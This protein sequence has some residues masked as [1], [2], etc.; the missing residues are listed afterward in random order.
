MTVH[1]TLENVTITVLPALDQ[2]KWIVLT[3]HTTH[4]GN[5]VLD[6]PVT[7]NGQAITARSTKAL[8][9]SNVK[10]DVMD[11]MIPTVSN[12]IPILPGIAIN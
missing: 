11:H 1:S 12:V 4:S 10:M 5:R 6:V 8:V 7:K 9:I 3:V 2:I